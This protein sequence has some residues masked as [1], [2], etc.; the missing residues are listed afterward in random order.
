MS[1]RWDADA[2]KWHLRI[3]RPSS[4]GDGNAEDVPPS[5]ASSS[6]VSTLVDEEFEEFEDTADVL[7]LG[8]GTLSRWSWPDI[9]GLN[10]FKGRLLHSAQWDVTDGAWEEG[11][12]GWDKKNVGVIGLVWN[13]IFE[14][15]TILIQPNALA[16][17]A[18]P[19]GSTALQIVPA[20]QPKVNRLVNFVRGKT[21]IAPSACEDRLVQLLSR[22]STGNRA[23]KFSFSRSANIQSSHPSSRHLH[24]GGAPFI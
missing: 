19:Q 24:R 11:V 10:N 1:A 17:L 9:E 15:L 21:W 3:R 2:G 4:L 6:Q 16:A 12:K 18:F 14:C 13:T 20:L 5:P 22:P 7:F 23:A 8:T